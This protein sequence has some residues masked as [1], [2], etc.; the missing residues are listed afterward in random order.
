MFSTASATVS[1]AVP[2]WVMVETMPTGPLRSSIPAWPVTSICRLSRTMRTKS[3]VFS[4]LTF[5]L[6]RS[7]P[8]SI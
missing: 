4:Q 6:V 8:S 1:E 5:S 2:T 3:M 7:V